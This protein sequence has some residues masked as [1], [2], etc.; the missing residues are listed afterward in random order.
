VAQYDVALRAY[1]LDALDAGDYFR[2]FDGDVDGV[3]T[4]DDVRRLDQQ[5]WLS[6]TLSEPGH[7]LLGPVVGLPAAAALRLAEVH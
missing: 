6:E 5:Y 7:Y 3:L 2:L 4:R 1:G